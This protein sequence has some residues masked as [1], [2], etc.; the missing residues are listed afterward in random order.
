MAVREKSYRFLS[1]NGMDMVRGLAYFPSGK[2][3]GMI[4]FVHDQGEHIGRYGHIMGRL[5]KEGYVVFGNDHMG[6][7][8]LAEQAGKL[9]SFSGENNYLH[10]IDDVKKM[11]AQVLPDCSE[12]IEQTPGSRQ[13]PILRCLVGTGLGAD[14]VK[15][16][17]VRNNDCNA[18][19][20]CGDHG[21]HSHVD[22]ESR[23]CKRLMR[24]IGRQE[25]ADVFWEKKEQ[26][27][28]KY[29]EKPQRHSW[30][31]TSDYELRK[32][33]ED[34]MCQISYDLYSYLTL[35]QLE[36]LF[37]MKEWVDSYP[38]YLPM[39]IMAGMKD[40]VSNYTRELDRVL[41]RLRY[42]DAKNIFYKYY[43]NSRHDI[44][45][46]VEAGEVLRDI[47][48]FLSVIE[49]QWVQKEKK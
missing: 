39:Y 9:G 28:N 2:F 14:I 24:K 26:K 21:F 43:K 46:D 37:Q 15:A 17:I 33:N 16:Y 38:E 3:R 5:A 11:F 7:G 48:H 12:L 1:T 40:P 49:K 31:T 4:Q 41:Q 25:S 32:Y 8:L 44:F 22:L 18:V 10:M 29:I 6:H 34:S 45:F 27:Y 47:L 35:L 13:R 30:R 20:L 36:H 19:I 23:E 42:S